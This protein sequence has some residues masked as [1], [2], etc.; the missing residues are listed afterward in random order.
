[1]KF[2]R[3]LMPLVLD[4]ET[5]FDS[6]NGY[7][8]RNRA[9]S[10]IEYIRDARFKAHGAGVV[11]PGTAPKW[12]SATLAGPSDAGLGGD[13][14]QFDWSRIAL[15]GH[16]LKFDGTILAERYGIRPALYI[17]TMCMSFAVNGATLPSHSLNALAEHYGL[18]AKGEMLTDGI[19]DLV[20]FQEKEL[21]EYCLHDVELTAEIFERMRDDFPEG[22]YDIMDWSIRAFTTPKLEIDV[23][24]MQQA[25]TEE[26]ARREAFFV[27]PLALECAGVIDEEPALLTKAGK[28]RKRKPAEPKKVFAS[29]DMFPRVLEHFG[30]AVPL[31]PSPAAAKKG[32]DKK[33]PALAVGDPEFVDMLEG[34]DARL[35]ALCEA[36]VAAKSTLLETRAGKFAKVGA[37]GPWPFDVVYSGAFQT[38]RFSGGAGGGGNPQNLPKKNETAA[39]IRRAIRAPAG[40]KLV[41][42]DFANIELRVLAWLSQDNTLMA[43]IK[44]GRDL[45][46]DF[47]SMFY[48]RTITKADAKE[49]QFA[50]IAVLGLGY[51]MGAEKFVR[52][53]KIQAEQEIDLDTAQRAVDLYR[54]TYGGVPALWAYLGNLLPFMASAGKGVVHTLPAVRW[55]KAGFVLPSGLRIRYPELRKELVQTKRGEREEWGYTAFRQ[56]RKEPEFVKLYGGKMTENLCQGL[57]GDLCKHAIR[58]C[59]SSLFVAQP[60][61][62]VHDELLAVAEAGEAG[63]YAGWMEDAMSTA[64]AWFPGIVLGAEVGIGDNWLEAKA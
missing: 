33:I 45:Y 15:V 62:Q 46:C 17:D 2:V 40:H 24:L 28:P 27:S 19:R 18:P 7:T 6:K 56:K 49:R 59:R 44:A 10:T 54:S 64:P 4:F 31:K 61:G 36:R 55:D 38:H 9:M 14:G 20:D 23:P 8:L 53:V 57:A 63:N 30:Y 58:Q 43:A 16:N 34:E 25:S 60:D 21:S 39:V 22:E 52:T 42:G 29:N 1:M 26:A 32:E 51:G 5:F 11:M 12:L 48:G 50:K 13:L 3:G 41:V 35:R 47:G 37:T